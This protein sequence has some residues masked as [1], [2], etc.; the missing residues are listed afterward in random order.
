ML[1]CPLSPAGFMHIQSRSYEE[2]IAAFQTALRGS[3]RDAAAWEGLASC[4]H[5]LGRWTAALKVTC[6]R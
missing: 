1:R 6:W 3:V 4:Y 2:G 5:S